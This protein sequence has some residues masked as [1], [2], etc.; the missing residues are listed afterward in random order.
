MK[1]TRLINYSLLSLLLLLATACEQFQN[2]SGIKEIEPL[3]VTIGVTL[4]LG[5]NPMPS[6]LNVRLVNFAERYELTTTMSPDKSVTVDGILPGI[7]TVTVS[8]EENADG[9][10]YIYAGN[11]VNIDI[12]TDNKKLQVD[13]AVSRSSDLLF[14]EVYYCGSRTPSGGSYFRD[15]FYEIYNNGDAVQNVRGLCIAMINP[16]TATANLPVWPEPDADKYVYAISMWQVPDTTD[17]PLRPGESIIIAQMADDLSIGIFYKNFCPWLHDFFKLAFT[18]HGIHKRQVIFHAQSIVF[19]TKSR[20]SMHD[21]RSIRHEN[22]ICTSDKPCRLV[23]GNE[24]EKRLIRPS[25][26]VF[27]HKFFQDF[28]LAFEHF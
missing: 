2:A 3:S 9:F 6:S 16:M 18:V 14:K 25:F 12:V 15:Q 19:R 4:N 28:I 8:G 10:T 20:R 7:Y 1:K 27:T 17:F 21:P 5:D 23:H 22:V 11:A 24:G 13:V 26:Q